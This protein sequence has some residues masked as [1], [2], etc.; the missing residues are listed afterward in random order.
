MKLGVASGRPQHMHT[1]CLAASAAAQRRLSAVRWL[2]SQLRAGPPP[3]RAAAGGCEQPV[4]SWS[5]AA[6]ADQCGVPCRLQMMTRHHTRL[7]ISSSSSSR[8]QPPGRSW[9]PARTRS[10]QQRRHSSR[11]CS[12]STPQMRAMQ[13]PQLY[14]LSSP[15][16][17]RSRQACHRYTARALLQQ[18]TPLQVAVTILTP[19]TRPHPTLTALHLWKTP[20]SSSPRAMLLLPARTH[21]SQWSPMPQGR[22]I[23]QQ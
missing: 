15:M 21:P 12:S 7:L 1:T 9:A 13:L 18:P 11:H 14:Q 6:D 16:A 19:P 4:A 3:P 17:H 20:N 5:T 10:K 2:C 23:W 8:R 22:A